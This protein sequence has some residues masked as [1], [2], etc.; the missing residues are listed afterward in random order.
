MPPNWPKWPW[1]S[2]SDCTVIMWDAHRRR[3][4]V[5]LQWLLHAARAGS[6]Q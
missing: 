5:G 6:K 1:R 4:G 3:G 2:G